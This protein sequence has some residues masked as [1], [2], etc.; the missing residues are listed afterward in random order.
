MPRQLL[1]VMLV[2]AAA[3]QVRADDVPAPVPEP[4]PQPAPAPAPAPT[5]APPSAPTSAPGASGA[6]YRPSSSP[7]DHAYTVT[8]EG[9]RT[10]HQ[11]IVVSSIAGAAV[12]L[13]A[14]G[15]YFNLDARSS[16]NMVSSGVPTDRTWTAADQAAYDQGK[17]SNTK[18]EI[19]YGAA[20]VALI[21]TIVAYIVT[22]PKDEV[23][24]IRP[25]VGLSPVIAPTNGGAV[26]GGSWGF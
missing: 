12:V 10:K 13:G 25:H 17:S 22:A 2:A 1:A 6:D 19:F 3:G 11:I 16:S 15:L 18:M 5:P 9:E 4:P 23:T 26:L 20:S 14:V 24:V 7:V 21:G 8:A